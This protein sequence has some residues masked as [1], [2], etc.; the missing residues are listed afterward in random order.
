MNAYAIL[1]QTRPQNID[2][3]TYH[4]M[5]FLLPSEHVAR[6]WMAIVFRE[7]WMRTVEDADEQIQLFSVRTN[8]LSWKDCSQMCPNTVRIWCDYNMPHDTTFHG[9]T[10]AVVLSE[11]YVVSTDTS[12][13]PHRYCLNRA[14]SSTLPQMLYPCAVTMCC[15]CG[16]RFPTTRSDEHEHYA[17]VG[18]QYTIKNRHSSV[19]KV[20]SLCVDCVNC[21]EDL[22]CGAVVD[23]DR[24]EY[25]DVCEAT[26]RHGESAI[27]FLDSFYVLISLGDDWLRALRRKLTWSRWRPRFSI[28]QDDHNSL[29]D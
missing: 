25:W 3:W 8:H 4:V 12:V 11:T 9:V 24:N 21:S 2:I 23:Y 5:P 7:F 26:E 10:Y 19:S 22:V 13:M 29:C 17:Y 27:Y 1:C 18:R 15:L 28:P 20:M 6:K 14:S 16:T